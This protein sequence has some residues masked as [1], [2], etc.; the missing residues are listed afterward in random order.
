MKKA[1]IFQNG[2]SQA[3]RLPKEFRFSTKEVVIIPLGNSI[4]LQPLLKT[5]QEVFDK[6]TP[7]NDFFT[8]GREDI[9]SQERKW[10]LF[11]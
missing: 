7:T 9:P 8:Q 10:E 3:V 4:V 11:R 2:H 5:W 1:K 6:I